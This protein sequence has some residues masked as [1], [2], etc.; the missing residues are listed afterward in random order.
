[1]PIYKYNALD[2]KQKNIEGRVEAANEEIAVDVL[3]DHG[4]SVISIKKERMIDSSKII[5]LLN[6]VKV[7]DL[8][9][10]SRQLAVLISAN[11]PIIKSL[12]VLREQTTNP[13]FQKVISQVIDEVEGG[14]KLSKAF[15]KYPKVFDGFFVSMVRSGETSGK[16]DEVLNYLANQ[17][18]KDYDLSSKIKGAMIYPVFICSGLLVVGIVMMIFVVPKLTNILTETGGELPISTRTLIWTSNCLSNYW[19]LI[20]I[21]GAGIVFSVRYYIRTRR[22]RMQWDYLKLRLPVFGKLF[23]KIS[24]VRFTQ[25]LSTLLMGGVTVTQSLEIVSN[26]VGNQVYKEIILETIKEVEGGKSIATVFLRH[27]E[28]PKMISQLMVMG[29]QTGKLD[30][31][32][33]KM[34]TFYTREVSNMVSNL[35]TLLEP[36]IM[37]IM[38]V[39]VGG[40]VAAIILPMYNLATQF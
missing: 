5:E 34:S 36:I 7:K 3:I 2:S 13:Y 12:K 10:F 33:D 16:L 19:W 18:E 24:M 27:N 20:G 1:M 29:E 39:A 31:I 28:V 37:I 21:I 40:L 11:L 38:G 35:V 17:I 32:F 6:R 8:V 4:L 25:S 15:A 23:Q 30:E 26:I 9:I 14:E 22:G